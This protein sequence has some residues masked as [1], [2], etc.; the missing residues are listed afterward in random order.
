VDSIHSIINKMQN[1][2]V[3]KDMEFKM[4]INAV[5]VLIKHF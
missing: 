3:N 5:H 4:T 1:V 2:N